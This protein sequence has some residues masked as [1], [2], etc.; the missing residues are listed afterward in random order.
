MKLKVSWPNIQIYCKDRCKIIFPGSAW[1]CTQLRCCWNRNYFAINAS[2]NLDKHSNCN[3]SHNPTYIHYLFS[4]FCR[5]Y[6]LTSAEHHAAN[7]WWIN[8]NFYSYR[9]NSIA[10]L[11]PTSFAEFLIWKNQDFMACVTF[12]QKFEVGWVYE[13]ELKLSNCS[14]TLQL[15]TTFS[16]SEKKT[17]KL[18]LGLFKRNGNYLFPTWTFKIFVLPT[19]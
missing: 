8:M 6:S 19:I 11:V 9:L 16:V 15:Q 13:L 4:L 10:K 1:W 17:Y 18:R 3:Y 5:S 14:E 12:M 7:I 2:H